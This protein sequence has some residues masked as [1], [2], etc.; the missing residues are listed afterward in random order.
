MK[1]AQRVVNE[2][3]NLKYMRKITFELTFEQLLYAVFILL[4]AA[5]LGIVFILQ[6]ENLRGHKGNSQYT[7][8]F[9]VNRRHW[10][11]WCGKRPKCH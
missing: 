5:N 11:I 7:E 9:V 3:V 6:I 8:T 10:R 1:I 4:M 2:A